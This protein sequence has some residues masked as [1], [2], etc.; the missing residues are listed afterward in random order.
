MITILGYR[1]AVRHRTLTPTFLCSN[2]STP[3]KFIIIRRIIII[4]ENKYFI[5]GNT[6]DVESKQLYENIFKDVINIIEE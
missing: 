1:Q 3:A 2:H 5:I 4:E 6:D